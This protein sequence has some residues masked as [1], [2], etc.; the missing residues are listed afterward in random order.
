LAGRGKTGGTSIMWGAS[1]E[2]QTPDSTRLTEFGSS[3][4]ALLSWT[5]LPNQNSS[6]RA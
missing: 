4:F 3:C 5:K 1:G 6:V 2:R